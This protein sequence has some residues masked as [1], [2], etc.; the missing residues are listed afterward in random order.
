MRYRNKSSDGLMLLCNKQSL[1]ST[2]SLLIS[3]CTW[4][5]N[6]SRQE[7]EKE[8][9]RAELLM[10]PP[11]HLRSDMEEDQAEERKLTKRIKK[12]HSWRVPTTQQLPGG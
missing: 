5:G 6:S 1:A 2:T 12:T 8:E 11:L 4:R 3:I 9:T 10:Q 7:R